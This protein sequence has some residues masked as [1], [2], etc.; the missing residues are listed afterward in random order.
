[1]VN[2]GRLRLAAG[3]R[4]AVP[5]SARRTDGRVIPGINALMAVNN[6]VL[7]CGNTQMRV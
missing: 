1:M 3:L 5:K 2:R 7:Q 6:R 4:S